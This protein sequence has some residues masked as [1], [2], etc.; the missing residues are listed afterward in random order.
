MLVY[1]S[2]GNS[3]VVITFADNFL[4]SNELL[5]SRELEIIYKLKML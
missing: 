5:R 2:I 1:F 3:D 4:R